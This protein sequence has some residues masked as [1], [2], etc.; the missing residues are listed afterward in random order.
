MDQIAPVPST[1]PT[2]D[3]LLQKPPGPLPAHHQ[4][5]STASRPPPPPFAG[6]AQQAYRTPAGRLFAPLALVCRR[7]HSHVPPALYRLCSIRHACPPKVGRLSAQ[8]TAKNWPNEA[9]VDSNHWKQ[10]TYTKR[11]LRLPRLRFALAPQP[12]RPPRFGRSPAA[13]PCP[14]ATATAPARCRQTPTPRQ[15]A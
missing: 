8:Q 6:S 15:S 9:K 7:H 4:Y 2:I 3:K 14:A 10:I 11:A 12:G 13:V 1:D 5:Y